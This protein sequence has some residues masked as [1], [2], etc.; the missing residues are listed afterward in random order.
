MFNDYYYSRKDF[1]AL[2]FVLLLHGE[3]L[4]ETTPYYQW[5]SKE[6]NNLHLF[7]WYKM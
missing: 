1:K 6:L 4:F 3:A 5:K 7:T 2:D